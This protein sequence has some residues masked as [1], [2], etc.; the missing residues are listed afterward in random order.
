MTRTEGIST[1]VYRLEG[2]RQPLPE[3]QALMGLARAPLPPP[4]LPRPRPHPHQPSPS[5]PPAG[6]V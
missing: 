3:Q 1:A 4:P 5:L 6:G 2:K